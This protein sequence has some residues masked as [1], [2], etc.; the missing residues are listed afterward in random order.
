MDS[1]DGIRDA[2]VEKVAVLAEVRMR[3]DG[4][5]MMEGAWKGRDMLEGAERAGG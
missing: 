5:K 1:S 3:A 2:N 4:M